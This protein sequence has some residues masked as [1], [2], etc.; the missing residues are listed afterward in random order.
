MFGLLKSKWSDWKDLKIGKVHEHVYLIQ[1]RRHENGKIHFRV[2]KSQPIWGIE[3]PCINDL[4]D[5]K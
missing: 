3:E 5:A 1:Y 4:K 2:E